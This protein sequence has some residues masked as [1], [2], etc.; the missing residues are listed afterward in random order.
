MADIYELSVALDLR[1]DLSDE[2]VTELRW[3]LGLGPEPETLRIVPAF[4]VVVEDENGEPVVEDHPAPLLGRHEAAWRVG[5]ALV[6][7]LVEPERSGNGPWALTVRQEVHPDDFGL[8][9]ALLGWLAT[10]AEDRHSP[11]PGAVHLGWTRF[12]ESD[13][14]E[15]LMVRDGQVVW[16]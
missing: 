8:T 16:P 2:E 1:Q 10:K 3:H 15:P 9:G 4:P 7:A 5:G 13:R 11:A 14:C 6:S 12:Y